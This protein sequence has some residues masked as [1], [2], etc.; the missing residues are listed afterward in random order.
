MTEIFFNF[1]SGCNF[2]PDLNIPAAPNCNHTNSYFKCG[3]NTLQCIP[4][5]WVCDND[6]ECNNGRDESKDLCKYSGKCGGNFNTSNGFLT[7]P[8]YPDKYPNKA[9]C[10]YTI[11]RPTNMFI[12]LTIKT[13]N[14]EHCDEDY[15]DVDDYMDYV[16][17]RDGSS[18]ESPL[19][20]TFCG[21]NFPRT[22]QSTKN[23]IWMK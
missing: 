20:A 2:S 4:W 6:H 11:S 19:I 13:Y 14:S 21:S 23:H 22:I 18:E 1:L 5:A 8:S 7:S 9:D 10:I 12:K 3:D 16:E 17:I 15:D